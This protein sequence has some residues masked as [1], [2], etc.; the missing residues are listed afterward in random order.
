MNT[1][2]LLPHH[3]QQYKKTRK[4]K[5]LLVVLQVIILLCIALAFLAMNFQE[6][7]LS[8]RS[9]S[10]SAAIAEIDESPFLLVTELD[11]TIALMQ[12]L[13]D[14]YMTNFPVAFEALW[15]E[16]ILQNLPYN[17]RLSRVTYSQTEIVIEGDVSDISDVGVY[18]Q[19]LLDADLFENVISG[20]I[21]S[22]TGGRFGFELRM[23]IHSDE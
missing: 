15:F 20:R 6:R 2:N 14:F 21:N 16:A 7:D 5:I 23:E 1:L 3:I 12:S 9:Q 18:R 17:T 13:E 10:L 4:L 22:Q 11:A 8:N 19:A